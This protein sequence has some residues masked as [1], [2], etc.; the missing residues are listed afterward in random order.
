MKNSISLYANEGLTDYLT[1]KTVKQACDACAVKYFYDGNNGDKHL[2]V[3]HTMKGDE[4][5]TVLAINI[6]QCHVTGR[7]DCYKNANQLIA[8]MKLPATGIELVHMFR[9][10]HV[11]SY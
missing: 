9:A 4:I 8:D 3:G 5:D 10:I 1:A 6:S 2:I 7:Y 11:W